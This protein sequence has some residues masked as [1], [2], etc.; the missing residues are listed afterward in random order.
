[1]R[2]GISLVKAEIDTLGVVIAR[3]SSEKDKLLELMKSY[4]LSG[5]TDARKWD[6]IKGG[7]EYE[8]KVVADALE[9]QK[10]LHNGLLEK[11]LYIRENAF[12]GYK[13]S[14]DY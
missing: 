2:I 3:S 1:M 6:V 11:S 8:E 14:V 7:F 5:E 9:K 10:R 12:K 4:N 13:R